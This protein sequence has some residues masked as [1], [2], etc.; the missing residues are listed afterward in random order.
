MEN[1]IISAIY[2]ILSFAV[3]IFCYKKYGKYGLYI[4]MSVLVIICN[5]QTTKISE[6]FGLTI[7][8]G[9]ISYGALFL[10]T[11]ILT[12]KYGKNSTYNATKISFITMA[13]FALLMY[14]FLQY[15]PSKIDFS[16]DALVTIFSYVPR[17][18]VGS[19][20]AYYISQR[21][22]AFL[23]SKLKAKYNKV[24]ISNNVS[25]MISQILDTLI[26]VTIAFVGIMNYT[27]I[28]DLIITMILFK[29]VIALLDTP[30]MILVTKIKD[31]QELN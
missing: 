28:I 5:I 8:L 16:Q 6:L 27:E 15:R 3:T 21:C 7:S 30:F 29:W 23:Y 20:L 2:L 10:T 26:F 12:E 25:T 4:W 1:I 9:N 17:V 13:I 31:N 11:D 24:W 22:D 14:I 19:L 18:T